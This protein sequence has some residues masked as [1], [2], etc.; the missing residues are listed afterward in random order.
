[1]PQPWLVRAGKQKRF[2][3]WEVARCV[4]SVVDGTSE[5]LPDYDL[6]NS[7][8]PLRFRQ[9][10]LCDVRSEEVNVLFLE[11][12]P[13]STLR[14]LLLT[15]LTGEQPPSSVVCC[16]IRGVVICTTRGGN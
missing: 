3:S 2:E 1:M 16:L 4:F 7:R 11:E 13:L 6:V 12:Y 5:T 15:R 14:V 9:E 10:T 8:P